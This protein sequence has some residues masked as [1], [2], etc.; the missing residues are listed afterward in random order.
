M[1]PLEFL[2]CLRMGAFYANFSI[3]DS[4]VY[5]FPVHI[6][7]SFFVLVFLAGVLYCMTCRCARSFCMIVLVVQVINVEEKHMLPGEVPSWT[8][9][10]FK[11]EWFTRLQYLSR[12]PYEV[13]LLLVGSREL[14]NE[15]G[16]LLCS[17]AYHPI[18]QA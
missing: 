3:N 7:P 5:Y 10:G 13:T 4:R 2:S 14:S 6:N 17:V 15:N 1:A 12:S 11:R 9:K 16:L 18:Y 8:P